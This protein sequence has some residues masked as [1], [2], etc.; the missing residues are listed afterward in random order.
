MQVLDDL[1]VYDILEPCYHSPSEANENTS[2]KLPESFKQLG[3]SAGKPLPVRKRMFG[4]AWP[5]RAPIKAGIIPS[6]PELMDNNHPVPCTVSTIN[7]EDLR[8]H[9][10]RPT[11]LRGVAQ[12]LISWSMFPS[13]INVRFYSL[14]KT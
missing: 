5:F 8:F 4:R 14:I 10:K 6:W 13:L 3:M 11:L 7:C 2:S 9:L 12:Y 1:N